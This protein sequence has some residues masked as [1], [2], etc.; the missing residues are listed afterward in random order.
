[1]FSGCLQSTVS[2]DTIAQEFA[3]ADSSI[4]TQKKTIIYF[5][6]LQDKS[7]DS[8][9]QIF[10]AYTKANIPVE[11]SN[12]ISDKYGLI[13]FDSKKLLIIDSGDQISA[14][15]IALQM[16][17]QFE[18]EGYN[19]KG[20]IDYNDSCNMYKKDAKE[21]FILQKEKYIFILKDK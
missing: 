1:M 12:T 13:W 20:R 19:Y 7:F 15:T 9:N 14:G 5:D 16:H 3:K 2:D 21:L 11:Y 6:V 4:E 10:D 8:F 18:S 17:S